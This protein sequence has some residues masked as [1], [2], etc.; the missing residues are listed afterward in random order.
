MFVVA[1]GGATR[2]GGG[3]VSTRGGG[4]ATAGVCVTFTD[5]VAIAGDA[6]DVPIAAAAEYR[7]GGRVGGT[8][9]AEVPA[10]TTEAMG[11]CT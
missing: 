8:R 3:G 9:C 7:R 10:L 4:A 2:V 11:C 5:G 1:E 6:V